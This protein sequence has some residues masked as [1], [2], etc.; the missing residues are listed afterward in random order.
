MTPS[1]ATPKKSQVHSI[2]LDNCAMASLLDLVSD[3]VVIASLDGHIRDFN[4]AAEV[5]LGYQKAELIGD[6]LRKLF[7]TFNLPFISP[8]PDSFNI[9]SYQQDSV[10]MS[11]T[12]KSNTSML[13]SL[14]SRVFQEANT[15][16]VLLTFRPAQ[17]E[18]LDSA[19]KDSPNPYPQA[20]DL[21]ASFSQAIS[22]IDVTTRKAHAAGNSLAVMLIDLSGPGRIHGD[23]SYEIDEQLARIAARRLH[24]TLGE[25]AHLI[26]TGKSELLLCH[27]ISAPDSDPV[28]SAE[29]ITEALADPFTINGN[30]IRLQPRIGISLAA[31]GR[32]VR[33]EQLIE[34]A[35]MAREQAESKREGVPRIFDQ[36]IG[37]GHARRQH[38]LGQVH[39]AIENDTFQLHYQLQFDLNS[40][41]PCGVE[42]LVRIPDGQGNYYLP[43]DFLTLAQ[44]HGLQELL[45]IRIL[46]QACKDNHT[47]I[48][49]GLLDT[50][51]AVNLSTGLSKTTCLLRNVETALEHSSLSPNRLELEITENMAMRDFEEVLKAAEGLKNLGVNLTIDDFGIGFSSIE[52]LKQLRFN[53]IKL[54]R[55]FIMNLPRDN[56]DQALVKVMHGIASELGISTIAEGIETTRQLEYLRNVG[57]QA[58]Q[59]FWYARPLPLEQ[60]MQWLRENV[61]R[62]DYF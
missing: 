3:S 52:R 19:N 16:C 50:H 8:S 43:K 39:E 18:I 36:R 24:G 27:E 37:T 34:E 57:I 23:Y 45:E 9:S 30:L 12:T 14:R 48:D 17:T 10:L 61:M 22:L 41:Q 1:L 35:G 7:P 15:D 40:L 20:A 13:V 46:K 2:S 5:L 51:M 54:D 29:R 59:G 33:P 44:R 55:S 4:Q 26:A 11:C 53:K 47:L 38:I 21:Y 28:A 42:A 25:D 31:I 60:L 49:S 32:K 58:G 56:R 62:V 6:S